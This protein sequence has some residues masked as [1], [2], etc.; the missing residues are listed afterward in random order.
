MKAITIFYLLVVIIIISCTQQK[1]KF[2]QG[3]WQLVSWKQI[4]GDTLVAE[5]PGDFSGSD[6]VIFSEHH[7]NSIGQFKSSDTTFINN[8]VAAVYTLEGNRCEETL[9]KDTLIIV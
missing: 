4:S 6:I 1:S 2:P 3:A 7:F 5:F 9:L 8:F